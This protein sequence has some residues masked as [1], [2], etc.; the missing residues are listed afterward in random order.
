MLAV[1]R[2]IWLDKSCY[3]STDYDQICQDQIFKVCYNQNV[4]NLDINQLHNNRW[5]E[6]FIST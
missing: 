1:A 2:R 6:Q 3:V 4:H 5:L